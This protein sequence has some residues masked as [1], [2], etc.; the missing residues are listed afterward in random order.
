MLS[1]HNN[2]S[3]AHSYD[4]DAQRQKEVQYDTHLDH[5]RRKWVTPKRLQTAFCYFAKI[6]KANYEGAHRND[7]GQ[8]IAYGEVWILLDGRKYIA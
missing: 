1:D 5:S 7:K 6:G 2:I 3:D 4:D 8:D